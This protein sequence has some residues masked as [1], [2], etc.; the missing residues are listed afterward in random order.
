MKNVGQNV[1][2]AL[3]KKL[4]I[5]ITI[6]F[7]MINELMKHNQTNLLTRGLKFCA[8]VPTAGPIL[9]NLH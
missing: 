2:L 4:N 8:E 5:Y 6:L 7:I 1:F 9:L 3:W